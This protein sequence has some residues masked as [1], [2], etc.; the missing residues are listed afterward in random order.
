MYKYRKI[1]KTTITFSKIHLQIF[2]C[3]IR[4]VVLDT[5]NFKIVIKRVKRK[6]CVYNNNFSLDLKKKKHLFKLFDL[7]SFYNPK[8]YLFDS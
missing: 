1:I 8:K 5:M 6:V 4:K 7:N 3:F 2:N